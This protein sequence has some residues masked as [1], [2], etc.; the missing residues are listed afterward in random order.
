MLIVPSDGVNVLCHWAISCFP[1]KI[2]PRAKAKVNILEPK[3]PL[4]VS[5]HV[6]SGYQYYS[7]FFYCK[8][9]C[10]KF[11]A[12]ACARQDYFSHRCHNRNYYWHYQSVH[13]QV[14][15][16]I[17]GNEKFDILLLHTFPHKG[18]LFGRACSILPWSSRNG[19]VFNHFSQLSPRKMSQTTFLPTP[20][21]RQTIPSPA[22]AR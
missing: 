10:F 16:R 3:M 15:Y 7:M 22:P 17:F 9:N 6:L 21:S 5:V 1:I 18:Q 4:H 19:L 2:R 12:S 13:Q 14:Y 8:G 20:A 11:R